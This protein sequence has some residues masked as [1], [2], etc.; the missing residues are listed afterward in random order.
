VGLL[1]ATCAQRLRQEGA[2]A[3]FHWGLILFL[4]ALVAHT[5]PSLNYVTTQVHVDAPALGLFLF[6]GYSVL[7]AQADSRNN[8]RWLLA[9]GVC[10]GLSAACK[11][12]LAVAAVG[13]L[14]WIIRFL[15][16]KRGLTFLAAAALAFCAIYAGIVVR[17]GLAPVILN[18]WMPGKMPWNTFD[19]AG[20]GLSLTGISYDFTDKFRTFLTF[21]SSYL[22]DYGIVTLA[23]LVLLPTLAERSAAATQMIRFLLFLALVMALVSIASAGKSGGDVNSR[24]LVSLPLTLA[25]IFAFAAM[26]HPANRTARVVGPA[27]FAALI[28]VVAL[29]SVGGLLQF[30]LKGST[31]LTEAYQVISSGPSRWYFPF[32]PL[33]HVLAGKKFRPSIDVAHSYA[34][35][36][37]PVDKAAFRSAL[38]ENV[39]HI[40]IPPAIASW[41]ADEI[42]RL[43]PEFGRVVREPQLENHQVITR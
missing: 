15:G 41:G 32:D 8:T 1:C 27:T 38:P 3:Q 25:A 4:F 30:S 35:V 28:F 13:F 6:T 16:A 23:L 19:G 2:P 7:R 40:A 21:I 31:T 43:L 17:D 5:V 20:G 22:R 12:N 10:A 9:A 34:A 29:A 24:A 42:L 39:E 18:L 37:V 26:L 36:G 33:A 14:I 11:I